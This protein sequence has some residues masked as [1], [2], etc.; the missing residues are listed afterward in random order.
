MKYIVLFILTSFLFTSSFAQN[1]AVYLKLK[2][3]DRNISLK[4]GKSQLYQIGADSCLKKCAYYKRGDSL[5]FMVDIAN[6]KLSFNSANLVFEFGKFFVLFDSVILSSNEINFMNIN[7]D[8]KP[9]TKEDFPSDINWET[10]KTIYSMTLGISRITC[11][12]QP[13]YKKRHRKYCIQ[14]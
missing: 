10:T 7:I 9:F 5:Y 14:K 4:K 11:I 8:T 1:T 2:L 6:K 13:I 12:N 3:N